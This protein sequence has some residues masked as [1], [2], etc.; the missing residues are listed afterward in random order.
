MEEIA[1]VNAFVGG[2]FNLAIAYRFLGRSAFRSDSAGSS[3]DEV[4]TVLNDYHSLH[5]LFGCGGASHHVESPKGA[6][7][8]INEFCSVLLRLGYKGS[9]DV[10]EFFGGE[11][12][13]DWREGRNVI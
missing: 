7:V 2:S 1:F 5:Y 13:D 10:V 12:E 8:S 6:V 4:D 11:S 3:E 9:I